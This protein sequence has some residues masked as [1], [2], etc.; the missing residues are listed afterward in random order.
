M[1]SLVLIAIIVIAFAA[2]MATG[3]MIAIHELGGEKWQ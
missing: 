2:G 1:D 3:I